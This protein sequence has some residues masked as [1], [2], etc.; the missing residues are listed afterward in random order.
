[1]LNMV[2]ITTV[3]TLYHWWHVDI[4]PHCVL[5]EMTL[6]W[7][8]II[9]QGS[10]NSPQSHKLMYAI[11]FLCMCQLYP[12]MLSYTCISCNDPQQWQWYH[13]PLASGHVESLLAGTL[14]DQGMCPEI[15]VSMKILCSYDE[16]IIQPSNL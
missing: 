8:N 1:M 14:T 16:V 11:W 6:S 7:L 3:A 15:L 9:F 10:A 2:P 5:V 13:L 4:P 12:Y